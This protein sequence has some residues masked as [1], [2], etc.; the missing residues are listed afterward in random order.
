MLDGD[1]YVINGSKCF[2]TNGPD[3]GVFVIFA[4]TDKS[5][6]N[7]GLSAF[8]I[9]SSFPGFSIGKIEEKMGLHGVH[10]SELVFHR[11]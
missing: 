7:K 4:M 9:E 1:H 6:G 8:I 5:K 10:T 2:I 3:A 11:Q